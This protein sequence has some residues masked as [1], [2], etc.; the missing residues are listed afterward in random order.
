MVDRM[1]VRREIGFQKPAAAQLFSWG[2]RALYLGPA[3]G[4]TPHRNAVGV[5]AIGIDGPFAL[6]H[7][8][9]DPA[10]GVRACRSAVIA[11][12]TLHHLSARGRMGFL[13]VDAASADLQRMR[14]LAQVQ[15]PRAAFELTVA[16]DLV[17]V[18]RALAE[19]CI[20]WEVARLELEQ[21]IL[22]KPNAAPDPRIVQAL[23]ALQSQP[24]A[25]P[26][27]A[28]LAGAV[29][30]SDSR[31]RRLFKAAT[32]LPFRR[33]RLWLAM[34]VA[35]E[36]VTRG[37]SLTAAALDAGFSSSAHLSAAFREMFG[38]EPSRLAGGRLQTRQARQMTPV[39]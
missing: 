14:S 38:L 22:S 37:E 19:D 31:F 36:A 3:M 29:G 34:E 24:G 16:E 20:G 11:P 26:S 25:R 10:A 18:L 17:R 6:A 39:S 2:A 32:G 7:D 30:L 1:T 15:T 21:R 9:H 35:V 33:Y 13:Y 5:L 4:L 12:N 28:Q 27:L 23:A 8:P